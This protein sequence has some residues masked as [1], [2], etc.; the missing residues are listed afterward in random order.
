[1]SRRENILALRAEAPAILPSILQCDFGNL[2]QEIGSL[3]EGGVP[4]IHLDVMDGNFVPN[5]SFGMP[6]VAG[7]RRYCDLPLDVHLMISNPAEYVDEF[8]EAG[9]SG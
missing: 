6:I 1:M 4:A 5:L 3:V 2:Q 8:Y 9:A 7:I